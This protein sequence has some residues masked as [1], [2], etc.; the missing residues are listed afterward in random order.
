MKPS[1][2]HPSKRLLVVCPTDTWGGVE[3]NVHLRVKSLLERG[4]H[5]GLIL[6]ENTFEHRFEDCPGLELFLLKRRPSDLLPNIYWHYGQTIK[7]FKPDC[8]FVPLKRDWWAAA[9]MAHLAGVQSIILYLGIHRRIKP[10]LK[11]RLI[12]KRFKAQLLVN[13]RW[14][15]QRAIIKHPL[16]TKFNT[17]LIY[18]GFA[19]PDNPKPINTGQ[20]HS[21]DKPF[22]IGCAGRLS[23]QKGFDL[24]PT[25]LKLLPEHTQIH[26]AGEGAE[27]EALEVL[28][29]QTGFASRIILLGA[30]D[31][32]SEFYRTLDAFLLPS[33]NEGMAN[34]LNEAMAHGLPIVS[35]NVPGS[36]EL[37]EATPEPDVKNPLRVGKHG[38][39]TEIENTDAMAKGLFGLMDGHYRFEPE[40][41]RQLIAQRHSLAQ[42]IDQTESLF[43][44]ISPTQKS[45]H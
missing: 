31:N 12:F 35:T 24:L 19:L 37:L 6:L 45:A 3:K 14:L 21:S 33:R 22:I 26:I 13:S 44:K 42:M 11:Y 7:R 2:T 15:Q 20:S 27:R 10:N 36:A 39:L 43:F 1:F 25:V 28:F 16:L 5:V 18:N 41:Q 32:M 38:I 9:V 29:T 30:V 17:H 34:V 23:R 40:E 4:H 8:V